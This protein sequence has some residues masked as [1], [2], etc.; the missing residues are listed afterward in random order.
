MELTRRQTG[1]LAACTVGNAASMTPAV[2]AVFGTFL[3][4]LSAE[5]GWP[6]AAIS[7]V[8]T[9][10]AL[11]GAVIYPLAG[12]FADAH[13]AR[14]LLIVAT[15]LYGVA[16]ALLSRVDG[17]LWHF[18]LVF[19]AVSL[20]GSVA[21]TPIYAK[22]IAE[23]F[24]AGRGTALGIGSGLGNGIGSVLF[25]ALAAVVIG[26][27]G[28]RAGYVAIGGTILLVALPTLLLL[29]RDAPRRAAIEAPEGKGLTLREAMRRPHFWVIAVAVACGAGCTT[30]IFSHVVPILADRG[31]GL[32]LA[33]TVLSVFALTTS[34][35]QIMC[36]RLLDRFPS[37]RMAM[38]MT[39][40]AVVGLAL[41]GFGEG[42]AALLLGGVL[43]GIAMGTQYGVLPFFVGRYFG[44]RAFGAIIGL[45]Y[46]AV[47]AAQGVTPILLDLGYDLQGGYRGGVVVAC[48]VL[49]GAT[50]LF[51]ALPR[52]ADVAP[53]PSSLATV[54]A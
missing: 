23:W 46:S 24:A 44:T 1:V 9:I 49:A 29:L 31:Y 37:P 25:P 39:A 17:A 52:Y 53:P 34:G 21:A 3:I 30:A 41:L 18:Y 27:F 43:L 40:L 45:M 20:F 6:R 36:G 48:A 35:W 54:T 2:H 50:A 51:A 13:G 42:T 14:R 7:V 32:D 19:F 28:W 8:L 47:I 38:P 33:T 12:R 4:P 10:M 16:I 26:R 11:T 22:V 15:S 5:F